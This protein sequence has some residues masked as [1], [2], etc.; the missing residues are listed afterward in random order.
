MAVAELKLKKLE[1]AMETLQAEL[2]GSFETAR[3]PTT[4]TAAALASKERRQKAQEEDV[5]K[6]DGESASSRLSLWANIRD[7]MFGGGA[8]KV[9]F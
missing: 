1:E 7:R 8:S 4:A 3:R 6:R 2:K 5:E 9:P